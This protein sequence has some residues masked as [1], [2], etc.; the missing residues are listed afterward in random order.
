MGKRKLVIVDDITKKLESEGVVLT[1]NTVRTKLKSGMLKL[2]T[3]ACQS[4]GLDIPEEEIERISK[5]KQFHEAIA[6]F[7]S[8][9]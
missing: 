3:R 5:T 7:L 2:A 6:A 4:L 1:V 9:G 8:K